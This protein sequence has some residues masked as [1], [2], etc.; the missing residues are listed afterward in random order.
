MGQRVEK[1]P[2]LLAYQELVCGQCLPTH[3]SLVGGCFCCSKCVHINYIHVHLQLI[4]QENLLCTR[5]AINSQPWQFISAMDEQNNAVIKALGGAV[6]LDDSKARN[7][8]KH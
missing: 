3:P 1:Y 4:C 7:C 6:G 2:N 5:L 8:E